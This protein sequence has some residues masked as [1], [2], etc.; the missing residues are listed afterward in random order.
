VNSNPR[1][2]AIADYNYLLPED[3]IAQFP[4]PLRSDSK[5]LLF[6]SQ[7]ISDRCFRDL[8]SLLSAENVVF[9]NKTRVIPARLQFRRKTGAEIEVFC[10]EPIGQDHQK[11]MA[12]FSGCLWKCLVGG[13]KKWKE[14]EIIY[15]E[16]PGDH[17]CTLTAEMMGR[18]DDAF[19]IRFSWNQP[20]WSFSTVLHEAGKIP[21]PPYFHRDAE[22]S[23]LERYQ[24]V[25]AER[26]GSVAAPTAGL[27]FTEEI[28]KELENRNVILENLTLHVGAGTFKP[29]SAEVIGDHHMHGE[30]F[31]I[32][33]E[34]LRNIQ[35]NI[36]HKKIIAVGTTSMRAL[37]SLYWLGVKI[38]LHGNL[39]DR[40]ELGQWEWCD[41][42]TEMN[43]NEAL[44]VIISW[45]ERR[46]LSEFTAST[47]I[48]IAPGFDFK[49]CRGL[50]TNFHMPQSTLLVLV[51]AFTNQNWKSIYQHALQNNYRFLSY[52]DS[53]LL[54][55]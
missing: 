48:M 40:P 16:I 45:C 22:L 55:R 3:R 8:T 29:V 41:I 21:L 50:I 6:I 14:N 28:L 26:E 31:S 11:A 27:H 10:L 2:I 44:D 46:G 51:S 47:S 17:Q 38:S 32:T 43:L 1:N 18:S 19:E 7:E 24:T 35:R 13:A 52:G 54:L 12:S 25:F 53:S 20:K 15:C 39:D 33:C 37:E 49:I 42:K 4:L 30:V 23:D 36:S 9:M 5:L 34:S